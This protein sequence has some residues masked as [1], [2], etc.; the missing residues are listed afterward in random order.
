M[1]MINTYAV[2]MM[3]GAIVTAFCA[4]MILPLIGKAVLRRRSG[5]A[6]IRAAKSFCL[7]LKNRTAILA[8]FACGV[9]LTVLTINLT[10]PYDLA[11]WTNMYDE[12]LVGEMV[13][14]EDAMETGII[15]PKL[16][17]WYE[18]YKEDSGL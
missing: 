5:N 2:L 7:F 8:S 11:R 12:M 1:T 18:R 3:L 17:A 13:L 16:V 9:M 10:S 15:S 4:G 6:I 14:S